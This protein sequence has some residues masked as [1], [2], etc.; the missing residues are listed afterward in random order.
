MRRAPALSFLL[1]TVFIDMLGL[2]LIVPIVPALMSS[3]SVDAAHAAR[4]SGLI[5][6]SY[7]ILQFLTAPLLGRLAD[8]YGRRPVLLAS[9]GFLGIDYLAH[10]VHPT[11][12]S[13]M[14]FHGLAGTF[15]GTGIVVN[16]YVADVTPPTGRAR[17]YGL[18]GA[19]FGLGFVAGPAI[20]GL[21]GSVDVRLPFVA[22]A[23]LALANVAYGFLILP[24]SRPGDRTMRLAFSNPVGSLAAV[25]RRPVL[26]RLAAARFCA[27]IAR[28]VQQALWTFFV[29]YQ[30]AWGTARTGV[31][32]ALGAMAGAVFSA[33]VIGPLVRRLGDKR[34]AVLGTVVSA[35]TLTGTAF[36]TRAGHIYAVQVVGVLAAVGGA[37]CQSW[38]SR[39]TGPGEQGTVQGALTGGAALAEALVPAAATALFAWSLPRGWPGLPFLAAATF[40]LASALLLAGTSG[41][42][43]VAEQELPVDPLALE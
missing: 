17:A 35:L 43:A 27:D 25:L 40:A 10:A 30:L 22:A 24:E 13:L 39:V 29:A 28:N 41:E 12:T 42:A 6:S 11:V 9:L 16:A 4:W 14:I 34:A 32:M 20:G 8:R 23:A 36:A 2:G 26:G 31:V 19:A 18:V 21:L 37:A 33:R 1:A 38:I 3:I 15:A 7:G 5:D